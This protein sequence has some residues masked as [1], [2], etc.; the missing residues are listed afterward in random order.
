V[1]RSQLAFSSLVMAGI[2]AASSV[3]ALAQSSS[4]P[5]EFRICLGDYAL[6]AA[7]TCMP[8]G[9]TIAVNNTSTLFNEAQCTCPISPG[10]LNAQPLSAG[11]PF[12]TQAGQCS[13]T[14]CSQFPVGGPF[15]FDDISS[16]SPETN[17]SG[18]MV[19]RRQGRSN[20]C[21]ALKIWSK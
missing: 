12:L 17:G 4:V 19:G 7:S 21:Q 6:R 20:S 3:A 15:Q 18:S 2:V 1:E 11:T 14:I 16:R 13:Q 10:R 9:K 8:D 5:H